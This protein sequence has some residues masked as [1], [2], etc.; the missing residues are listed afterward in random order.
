M[1]EW[2]QS[3]HKMFLTEEVHNI[4]SEEIKNETYNV[5]DIEKRYRIAPKKIQQANKNF[6]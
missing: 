6:P 3:E 4:I 1:K 5:E 2:L